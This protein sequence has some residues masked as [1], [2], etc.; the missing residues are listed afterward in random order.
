MK[1]D[2]RGRDLAGTVADAQAAVKPLVQ[3]PY[4]TEWAGAALALGMLAG[5]SAASSFAKRALRA[6]SAV[7][8]CVPTEHS[9]TTI[10]F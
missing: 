4:R 5:P 9:V 8:T 6:S 2:V 3:A 1:F 10:L 7:I